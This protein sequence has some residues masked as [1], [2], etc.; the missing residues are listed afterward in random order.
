MTNQS[1]DTQPALRPFNV[2][3]RGGRLT[4][5]KGRVASIAPG[6]S[7]VATAAVLLTGNAAQAANEC[8]T[9]EVGQGTVTCGASDP[10]YPNYTD[11]ITYTGSDGL[12]L[13]L[14]D[15]AIEVAGLG[16]IVQGASGSKGHITVQMRDGEVK[17]IGRVIGGVVERAYGLRA[18]TEGDGAVTVQM[19]GGEIDV[20]TDQF[21]A[22]GLQASIRNFESQADATAE[23]TDGTVTANGGIGLYATS[24][25]SGAT[26]ARMTGGVIVTSSIESGTGNSDNHGIYATGLGRNVTAHMIKGDVRTSAYR[27]NGLVANHSFSGD[28]LAQMDGGTILTQGEES[29]G[30]YAL[31]RHSGRETEASTATARM[32]GGHVK[33]TGEGA[34]GVFARSRGFGTGVAQIKDGTITT[35]GAEAHGVQATTR[36]GQAIVSLGAG[37]IVTVSGNGSDGIRATAFEGGTGS[38]DVE[39]AGFVRGGAENGAA[40]RTISSDSARRGRINIASTA[41]VTA[42]ASGVAIQVEGG[43]AVVTSAGIIT[44]D[45]VFGAGNDFLI[46]TGGNVTGRIDGGAGDND[47]LILRGQIIS[48]TE[49]N[50]LNWE[51]VAL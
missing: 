29:E 9:D 47:R 12:T 34:H 41:T 7:V 2:S 13:I 14:D 22:Y 21:T 18:Y 40:I 5:I 42:G 8:G 20:T 30:I 39:V 1:S 37:A 3:V 25:S 43:A 23:M 11:G 44:G 15:P 19:S 46:L 24:H 45:I 26:L 16:A 50:F 31:F 38:F 10:S 35:E 17:T 27:S 6:L 28:V 49:E 32:N 33:T 51:H 48:R 4:K 36:D